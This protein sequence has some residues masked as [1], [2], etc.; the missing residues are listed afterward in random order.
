MS[1]CVLD[2]FASCLFKN[3]LIFFIFSLSFNSERSGARSMFLLNHGKFQRVVSKSIYIFRIFISLFEL[4]ITISKRI[5][6]VL[7]WNSTEAY[8][9]LLFVRLFPCFG[10]GQLLI[11]YRF[12][13]F[14]LI[15]HKNARFKMTNHPF[16]IC[17]Y[18]KWLTFLVPTITFINALQIISFLSFTR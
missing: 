6:L 1:I 3:F 4:L 2:Q 5:E 10:S 12:D 11:Y 9:L 14:W 13:R 18:H 8:S 16:W 17:L 15:V 7:L